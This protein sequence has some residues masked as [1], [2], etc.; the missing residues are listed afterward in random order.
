M[1]EILLD[2]V[3]VD[4]PIYNSDAR[5]LKRSLLALGG[6]KLRKDDG[7]VSVRALSDV[8][9][10]IRDGDRIGLI[11]FNGAG[12]TTLLRVLAGIYSPC[13]GSIV[14]HGRV[15]PLF[16]VAMGMDMESTGYENI[17][18]KGLFLGLTRAEIDARLHDIAAFTELGNYLSVPVRTYS[19]GMLLRLAFAIC[20]CI[21]PEIIL[22]D[23]WIGVGDAHF[24]KKATDRLEDFV[25]RSSILVLAS[26]SNDLIRTT[27]NKAALMNQGTLVAY[28]P[29]DVVLSQYE[30]L[31]TAPFFRPQK[32]LDANPDLAGPVRDGL[33]APWT[34]FMT[35]GVFEP[36]PMGNGIHL[37]QFT[38]DPVYLAAKTEGNAVMAIQ[39]LA[40]VLPFMPGFEAPS[41]WT[42]PAETPLPADFVPR[43]GETLVIPPH[44]KGAVPDT[45]PAA[46]LRA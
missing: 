8:S 28:G 40:Q 13:R 11:G 16:D 20:T 46:F 9:M 31:G 2:K 24:L 43:N 42:L 15:A 22:M 10:E 23:E 32:Y 37:D 44:Y 4:F 27:C 19:S 25:A 26:H 36:R 41:G 3:G 33:V 5:S 12:K 30:L 45:L 35:F 6:G 21:D 1:A 14:R 7:R 17:I 34:H 18:L 39:R 29:V 38:A